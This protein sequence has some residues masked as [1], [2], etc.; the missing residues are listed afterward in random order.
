MVHDAFGTTPTRTAEFARILR[1]E[2]ARMYANDPFE[3][4]GM[5]ALQNAGVDFL[6]YPKRGTLSVEAIA[7]AEYLFA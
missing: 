3:C 2:F 7:Q 6:T 1:E 4:L 5:A